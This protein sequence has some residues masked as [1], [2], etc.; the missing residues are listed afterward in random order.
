VLPPALLGDEKVR[1]ALEA[2]YGRL[3]EPRSAITP[4]FSE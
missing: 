2:A 1:R 3:A 4:E